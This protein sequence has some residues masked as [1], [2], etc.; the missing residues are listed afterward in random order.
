VIDVL[1]L[2]K[3]YRQRTVVDDM[4]F[5]IQPG[6]VTGFLGRNGAG[7]TTTMR[8][9]L[10][11]ARPDGGSA[12]IG[13]HPYRQ[14]H[15]PARRVGALLESSAPHRGMTVAGHLRWVA[16]SNKIPS[17]RI[18]EVL[19]LV[20]LGH[21]RRWRVGALSLGMGQRL[22]LAAALLGDPPVLI[23]DEPTN[24]LDADGIRW[25][26][27]LLRNMAVAG[28]TVF[29]SSHLMAEMSMVADHLIIIHEGHVVADSSIL[30]LI[31]RH[32]RSYARVRT[33]E[34]ERLARVLTEKGASAVLAADGSLEV[35]GIT[36]GDIMR[37]AVSI[38]IA[39][40]ELTT[41]AGS[42]EDAFFD[43]TYARG[44]GK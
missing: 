2:T 13:G 15:Y 21:A 38:G 33:S 43:I 28:K 17:A 3:R 44:G 29:L 37:V 27:E 36:A 20:D 5:T 24:G 31:A 22:G 14:V 7:K 4:T 8:M 6:K 30:D 39:L 40:D 11:L 25:L 1:N 12:T 42:L 23:L 16:Q 19:G 34:P 26:R 32:A 10:G 9:L 35:E 41:I 18:A